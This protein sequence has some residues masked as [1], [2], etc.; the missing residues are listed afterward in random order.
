MSSPSDLALDGM[1][2][3]INW[4][5]KM[6][7]WPFF[8]GLSCCFVE[9]A[10]AFT[11][12]YDIARF[13][14]EVFRGSPRQADVLIISGTMFK[15]VAPVA[16]RLYEQMAGPKW[17]IS[18]GSCS[19]TGGMY[20]V[21]SV[22]QGSDQIIPVDVYVPGCPPRPEALF[23]GL[24]T[25]Q[26]MIASGERP[27][28]SVLHLA[29][30]R[31]GGREDHL[32]DGVTKSRDTRG[33]GYESLPIRGTPATE[34]FFPES[35]AKLMW[36][37]SAPCLEFSFTESG[38]AD[39][40]PARFGEELSLRSA[41][42]MP[43]FQVPQDRVLEVLGYLKSRPGGAYARL[44]DLT[45]LDESARNRPR[46][47]TYTLVYTLR[48]LDNAD[49]V[50]LKVPLNGQDPTAHSAT[51]LW[52]SATWYERE[53]Q[54]MFGIRFAGL[55]DS[56]PLLLPP[57]WQGHPLRKSYQGRATQMAPFTRQEAERLEPQSAAELM[58]EAADDSEYLLN[59][60]PHHYAT[61][62]IFRYVLA[63]R[64][65][66]IRAVEMDIGY[67]HRGVEKIGERQTWHQFIPYTDR[68]DYLVGVCNNLSY[69]RAVE[70]LAGIEV[71]E[72]AQYVRVM[73]SE[74]FRISNHL[75][76]LGTFVQDLGMMS[77]VFYTFR[78]REMI[79]DIVEFITGGRMH[80]S[81]LRIGGLAADL[82]PGW[83]EMIDNFVKV[84]PARLKEYEAAISKNPIFKARTKGVGKLSLEQAVDWGVTGP[85]LRACG[86]DWDLRKKRPYEAYPD[87]TFEVATAQGGDCFARYLVRM[88]EMRQSLGIVDQALSRMPAGRH[89]T[90]DYR[91]AVPDK[92]D[93][94]NDIESLIH[95]F[96]NVTRGPRMPVGEAY[97]ATESPRGEQG[98]YV[99]SDGGC[100]AYRMRLRTPGFAN[101]Q[102]I[103]LMAVGGRIADFVAVLGSI[104]YVLPD[105]DR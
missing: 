96:V 39:E 72:R 56:R 30:G 63:L 29:G 90:G 100:Q 31:Q 11:P 26:K 93:T 78:E 65:E 25:L 70:T 35:R 14:A 37:P 62:G 16:L 75:V 69:L 20:D 45:A 79:M 57:A 33:P 73:L 88:E 85:N 58:G 81:W 52:P 80:P 103:P 32:T 15:K 8:F 41:T 74:L 18:M 36:T 19:N 92:R 91:Y 68:V 43:T 98:Y 66:R 10:T 49:L 7:L 94:L 6:S 44:E 5:R 77:P 27:T 21:Y 13:G 28:R 67:H 51:G 17:V 54:D 82:P 53:V 83:L 23:D 104:D 84:F 4:S 3:I 86:L 12:R 101:L 22:V 50:R 2:M 24:V 99:V 105:I 9:E 61:H 87:F 46:P 76:W 55:A 89:V 95:H 97:A 40:L 102:V 60:G 48:S 59:F 1:D 38:L 34:P 64:G 47:N 42:D 71:P